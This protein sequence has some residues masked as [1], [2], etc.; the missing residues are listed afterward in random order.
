MAWE[1]KEK[2]AYYYQAKRFGSQVR[3][4]YLGRGDD[5]HRAA[6]AA[7]MMRE[8]KAKIEEKLKEIRDVSASAVSVMADLE[9]GVNQLLQASLLAAGYRQHRGT[10][11]KRRG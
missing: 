5:A 3:K 2:R 1:F 10:W 4:V 9:I 7:Q 8:I 6:E 11:R